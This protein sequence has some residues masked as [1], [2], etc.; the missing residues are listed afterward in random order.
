MSD[1]QIMTSLTGAMDESAILRPGSDEYEKDNGSYFSA[2]E[3]EIKPSY[4]AK[5]TTVKQ[6]QGLVRAL[7]PCLLD[8]SC[9]AAVRGTGHTPFAGS[10]NIQNG[11]TID[12]RSLK[13]IAVSDRAVEVGAGE[14]WADVYAELE[15]HGLTT[16]GG[17]VGR[18]SVA[19][20]VLGG[21]L[22][23]ACPYET[24]KL[25]KLPGG[26]SLFSGKT[27]FACDSVLEFE[28]VLASH[29]VVRANA[30]VNPDL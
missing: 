2:F 30:E 8:E 23:H 18:V 19:G 15:K 5:P 17:R 27:G 24:L 7:R 6:V 1:D 20:L 21:M 14:V 3:N 10:A 26:L 11:V 28:V 25:I 12:T 4:I 22:T 29:E 16:A 13:G 9:R